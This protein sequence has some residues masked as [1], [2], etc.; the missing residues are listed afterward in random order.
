MWPMSKRKN[1][2]RSIIAL[3]GRV[4]IERGWCKYCESE[5]FIKD[6]C[7]TC[8]GAIAP[9][10]PKK[11]KRESKTTQP[12]KKPKPE[13]QDRILADQLYACF[14]CGR[15]FGVLQKRLEEEFILEITWDHKLPYVLFQD[16]DSE[17]FVAACQICN[18]L[19]R[20]IIFD[21]VEDARFYLAH[22]RLKKGFNY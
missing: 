6:G 3:F 9:E 2:R 18:A 14:Y 21:T 17:N 15:P 4:K 13:D 7:L 11:Y 22:E 16:S 20:D 1:L 5:A 8:C 19:K 12:R 10:K